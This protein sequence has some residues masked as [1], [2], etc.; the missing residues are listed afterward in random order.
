MAG[1]EGTGKGENEAGEIGMVFCVVVAA[2]LEEVEVVVAAVV[3]LVTLRVDADAL[4]VPVAL[5][6]PVVVATVV[7]EPVVVVEGIEMLGIDVDDVIVLV[8]EDRT[9]MVRVPLDGEVVEATRIG[10]AASKAA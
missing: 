4:V 8:V 3:V 2:K 10:S 9:V 5:V 6:E 7:V 1:S